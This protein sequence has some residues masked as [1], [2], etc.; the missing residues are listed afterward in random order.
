MFALNSEMGA[1]RFL[2]L[3]HLLAAAFA[4]DVKLN[5]KAFP[6]DFMF[7]CATAAYQIEGAWNEDGKGVNIWDHI[8]HTNPNYTLNG[9]N[10]DIT[11]DSYHKYK[12]DVSLLKAMNVSHYRFSIA[13][14]R[15]LPNGY[16][17]K[18]NQ[19]GVDYYNNL[20]NELIANNI[21]PL[22]TL[23][24]WDLPQTLQDVGGWPNEIIVD[25][26]AAY[27]ETCFKLFGD[28]VKYW[29]TFNEAK[30]TCSMG[31][32]EGTNAPGIKAAGFGDYLCAHNVLKAHA[33]AYH[34]Y[35]D[36]YRA[37]QKGN[38]GI[39]I[40]SNWWEPATNSTED[41][42]ASE[43]KLHFTFGWYAN[44]IFNGDYPAI[45]KEKIGKRSLAQGFLKSRLPSFTNDEISFIKGT[46]DFLGVNTYSASLVAPVEVDEMA[47]GYE[48]D[49][50]VKSWFADEW[51]RGAPPWLVVTP[52]GSRKLLNWI[53]KTYNPSKIII[54]ENGYADA[55]GT[56]EDD[57]RI[58]YIQQYLSNIKDA[59]DYDGVNVV[60]YTVWSLLDNLEWVYGFTCKFGL[61]QV[62][63][64]SP[65]RTRT[66]K[67]SVTFY[68]NLIA[69]DVW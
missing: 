57:D 2:V 69:K 16:T 61:Y 67:K 66:P 12:E 48:A 27:A 40:D 36:T 41:K 43:T 5:N 24:H 60:G 49:A 11:C 20:I 6:A 47:G 31:Y 7:G 50:E 52:W 10:G 1:L 21:E 33:K 29:M 18:I 58:N 44:A 15:I 46:A 54:T 4:D 38:V 9:D 45:M 56:L 22:V 39:V 25:L 8:T 55:D 34:I 59:M 65:N 63:F 23:Y 37:E 53:Q 14:T 51:Q 3:A 62:D 17:N 30:Q 13:W 64:N 26:Y 28:R 68:K 32:G 35:D 42:E 19:P